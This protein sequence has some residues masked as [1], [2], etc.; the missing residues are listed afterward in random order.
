MFKFDFVEDE[1]GDEQVNEEIK[2]KG[3]EVELQ[4]HSLSD[5]VSLM[6][7]PVSDSKDVQIAINPPRGDLVLFYISPSSLWYS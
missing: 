1:E 5:L 4:Q 7:F 2:E 6:L 3:F